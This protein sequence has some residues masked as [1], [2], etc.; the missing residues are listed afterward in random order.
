MGLWLDALG[1]LVA[2]GGVAVAVA[3]Y[4]SQRRSTAAASSTAR[5][6]HKQEGDKQR[7]LE[8]AALGLAIVRGQRTQ[9]V[10]RNAGPAT[11]RDI[12]LS[13]DGAAPSGLNWVD[14]GRGPLPS[15]LPPGAQFAYALI[16]TSTD[17]RNRTVRVEWE[18]GTGERQ[19]REELLTW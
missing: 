12:R 13:I 3:S 14:T 19:A 2:T 6:S 11:A 15:H 18:D 1:V 17:R 8:R 5:L 16:P 10:I 9:L 7:A 4:R